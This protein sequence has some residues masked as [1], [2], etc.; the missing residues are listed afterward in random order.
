G[1]SIIIAT[2]RP[3]TIMGDTAVCANPTDERYIH[4]KGKSVFIPLINKK[5]PVIFDEY[6][7]KEFGTGILKITPAHDI[8]DYTI[9]LKYNLPIIDTLNEDGT[10]SEAAQ[11]FV[12]EDRFI[13]RKKITEELKQKG[14]LIKEE[15]YQ[16]RLGFSQRTN[17]IA[18]PKI[19]TQ[20]FIKMK[21]L[22]GP[23]LQAV[24]NGDIKIHPGEKFF[25]TYKYW[26]ENV[27]DW[28]ISRQLWWGQQIPAWYDDKGNFVVAETE[29][30]AEK[31][32]HQANNNTPPLTGEVWT[33][34]K[35]DEDVLDTWF[36]S[37]LWPI[38]VFKGITQPG[39]ID[40]DYYYPT[41]ILVTGQD[42]IFF[43]V[44]RMIMAGMEYMKEK[45]F[46]D[47]YFTGMVR[48]KL[49]RK[50]SKQLGNSPDL[51]ALIEKYGAD[52]VRFGI[53][54]SSPAG[55]DL[56]F[57]EGSLE[58]GRNFN[59]KLWNALKLVKMWEGRQGKVGEY[60]IPERSG[61]NFA[62]RWFQNRLN[63]AITEVEVL[64][65]QFKLNEALKVIYSLIWDDFCSWYLEWV[66]PGFEQPIDEI[67]YT[68]TIEFFEAL[69]QLLHP[70][71]PFITEEIHHL[72]REQKVDLVVVQFE[73]AGI[74]DKDILLRGKIL[75]EDITTIR[76]ARR[77][78]Q[79]KNSEQIRF[80]G[81]AY[82][83]S[84][85][86]ENRD[87]LSLLEK[88]TNTKYFSS[89]IDVGQEYSTN[90]ITVISSGRTF[91]LYMER[92][93]DTTAQHD[94]LLKDLAHLKGF[95]N[96]VDSKL[97]NEKFVQNAKAEIIDLERKKKSDAEIKIRIIEEGLASLK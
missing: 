89:M 76:D 62:I 92:Q 86:G 9:G 4:L 48:D 18:E 21:E 27:K 3:E 61:D 23:A 90:E 73:K 80:M 28:C 60:R 81:T 65:N 82:S 71:M 72:L 41:S 30:E 64:Y 51:L 42:I 87:M 84:F 33:G 36:S 70:F 93:I 46:S 47:V 19:S 49:G 39:N 22:A 38:E 85:Y 78:N 15:E 66:K 11:I 63:E 50:M 2:Q 55:N 58:Q 67:F 40:I 83:N 17:V 94:E 44:S 88:Q 6:V 91:L 74:I 35:Q 37:W 13:V 29:E 56:L 1:G 7:D 16:T 25:A 57:D 68:K 20:W 32:F 59:N 5:I 24:T 10:L 43:W 79:I 97:N 52:A 45:P 77:K 54:I 8:N 14:Y 75:K 26:L 96:S 53:M 34:L 31:I 95:L 12:G 69:L